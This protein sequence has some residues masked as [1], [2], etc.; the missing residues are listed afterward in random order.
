MNQPTTSDRFGVEWLRRRITPKMRQ[1]LTGFAFAFVGMV[2]MSCNYITAKIAM[3]G[4]NPKTFASLWYVEA[5]LLSLGLTFAMGQGRQLRLRGAELRLM[6][7]LGITLTFVALFGWAGLSKMDPTFNS[8]LSR[9]TPMMIILLGVVMLKE[10]VRPLE[11]VA[12]AVMVGGG[13]LSTLGGTWQAEWWAIVLVLAGCFCAA[14]QFTI[15]KLGDDKGIPPL[16]VNVY[17]IAVAAVVITLVTLALGEFDLTK[18]QPRHWAALLIGALIGPCL[19][20]T[21]TFASYRYWE[22][23]R[24][25]MVMTLQPLV[26]FPMAWVMFHDVPGGWKLIGGLVILVGGLWLVAL[27]RPPHE[28]VRPEKK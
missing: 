1:Q 11:W 26:V 10:Q 2:L 5:T 20:V 8:F 6:L 15:A 17:R 14:L 7:W 21:L 27:H 12:V 23:T 3:E 22:M 24:T 4:F 18:A 9:L 13:V 19:S 25:A 28:T 16:V